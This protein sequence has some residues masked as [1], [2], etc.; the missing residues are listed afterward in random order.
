MS[1][2]E[3]LQSLHKLR[4]AYALLRSS[5]LENLTPNG[6]INYLVLIF[7]YC[8]PHNSGTAELKQSHEL[9]VVFKAAIW[10]LC[11]HKYTKI[12]YVACYCLMKQSNSCCQLKKYLSG[13]MLLSIS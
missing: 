13:V 1:P 3:L 4:L 12:C 11:G 10:K 2:A 7:P 5:D 8:C 9:Q 6:I